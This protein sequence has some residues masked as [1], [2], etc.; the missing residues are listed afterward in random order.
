M[1]KILITGG[2]GF[3]G[4]NLVKTLLDKKHIV[5]SLDNYST[6]KVENEH[7]GA[8][9]HRGDILNVGLMDRDFDLIYH[10]ASFS[11]IQPSFNLPSET[12]NINVTGTQSVLEFAR[13]TN[14]KVVYAGSSSK[15]HNPYLS[16]YAATKYMG[17]ELVKTY[18]TV[19]GIDA[20]IA[21]FYNVY[22][23]G[24]ITEGDMAAVIG[25]FRNAVNTNIPLTII[26]D[27]EQRRDFTH[28]F[29]ICEGLFR[30]GMK[31]EKHEEAWELGSGVNYSINEVAKMFN[32]PT[33]NEPD[34]PGNYRETLRVNS[35][36][37][38]RLNWK[39]QDRLKDYIN[40]LV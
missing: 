10:L 32:H 21:R 16:P 25:K 5:H 3:I 36:T 15:H 34:Q 13:L 23:P 8:V 27:G 31:N 30:I 2:A 18:R 1:K 37:Q 22:G 17:E 19:Y 38:Y 26:G 12:Y 11:R 28:I 24:E 14:A 35:D 6:G 7:K 4:S 40:S 29:D 33:T 20:E 39:P 9:Y